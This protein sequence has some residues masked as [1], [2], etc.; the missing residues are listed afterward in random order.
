MMNIDPYKYQRTVTKEIKALQD[1]VRFLIADANWAEDGRYKEAILKGIIKKQL[2]SHLSVGTGFIVNHD[3]YEIKKSKQIDIIIYD[4]TIPVLFKEGDFIVTTPANVKGIIE[5]K[6]SLP[7]DESKV[8]EMMKSAST[9]GSI[10]K[11]LC[12]NGIFVFD[13]R[14][15]NIYENRA[16]YRGIKR[17]LEASR[18]NINHVC[19]GENIFIKYWSNGSAKARKDNPDV[20]PSYSVYEIN[21][22]SFSYFISNLLD[23]ITEST[24]DKDWFR[25]PISRGKEEYFQRVIEIPKT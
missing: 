24:F 7:E 6:S 5:V 21:E 2:P 12:F 4:N 23:T 17:G 22:M 18:G 13:Q 25:Y 14:G 16:S 3:E 20:G 19:I 10:L 15:F 9:N 11:D 1:R 8:I